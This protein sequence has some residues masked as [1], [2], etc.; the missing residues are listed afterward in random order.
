MSLINIGERGPTLILLLN[1]ATLPKL[2]SEFY[3]V[4]DIKNKAYKEALSYKSY[5]RSLLLV[6]LMIWRLDN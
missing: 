1:A 6:C 2:F 5:K 3:S 4:I